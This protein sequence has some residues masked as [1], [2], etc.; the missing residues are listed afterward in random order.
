MQWFRGVSIAIGGQDVS[1]LYTFKPKKDRALESISRS[2]WS[3]GVTPNMVTAA[4]LSMAMV[5]GYLA[6]TGHLL[7]GILFFIISACL[8]IVDGSLA[9]SCGLTTEFGRY[10]D[11]ISDRFSEMAVIIGAVIG[12]IPSSAFIV[13]V[14][15]FVLMASRVYN[16]RKGTNSDAAMFGRPERVTLLTLGLLAPIP[17]DTW[18]FVVA[19][20]LCF[21]SSVQILMS[22][23]GAFHSNERYNEVIVGYEK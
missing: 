13:I 19:G 4:G 20:F 22:C 2:L 23:D 9:R 1:W 11:S 7:I 18:L 10:F 5:A 21:I 16:H 17:C 12:G 6:M 15:S 14:G 3:A 8:D